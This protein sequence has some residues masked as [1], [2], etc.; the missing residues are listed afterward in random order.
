MDK[1][2]KIETSMWEW[3]VLLV[4]KDIL[5][6]WGSLVCDIFLFVILALNLEEEK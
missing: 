3:E 5:I 1:I 2:A 4:V 6:A